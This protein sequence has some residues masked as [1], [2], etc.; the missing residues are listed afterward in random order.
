MTPNISE[1]HHTNDYLLDK[2]VKIFQPVN[3]YRASTDAVLVS[4]LISKVKSTD[5]ILDVG[6]GTGA[7]SLCLASRFQA[8]RPQILGLELQSELCMLSNQSAQANGFSEFL[9]YQNA[10]IRQKLTNIT[11]CS[12][13]HVISNPPYSEHDMPSPNP[14]KAA[15]HNHQGLT[16]MDWLHFCLKMTAPQG[17]LYFINRAEAITETLS[18]LQGKAGAIK[19]IPLFSKQGQVAKRVMI[20]AQKDS[21]APTQILPGLITH[22]HDGTYTPQTQQILRAGKGFFD[23]LG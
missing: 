19:I 22:N 7:I 21:K 2:R 8:I 3:G 15:A 23:T 14:S 13:Q 12:F 20:T 4:S 11:P 18:I 1:L 16:L 5:K 17:H 6:S 9:S 10:D